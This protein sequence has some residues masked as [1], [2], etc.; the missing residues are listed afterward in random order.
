MTAYLNGYNEVLKLAGLSPG[1]AQIAKGLAGEG[2]AT[3]KSPYNL[4]KQF[5]EQ[6]RLRAL[7]A[8]LEAGGIPETM[9]Y[10]NADQAKSVSEIVD[11]ATNRGVLKPPPD[12][13]DKIAPHGLADDLIGNLNRQ[14]RMDMRRA[15]MLG[16]GGEIGRRHFEDP[17]EIIVRVPASEVADYL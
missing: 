12:V 3:L 8:E 9:A 15:T 17:E 4:L 11:L 2:L 10:G 5:P 13:G 1:Y 6:A 16:M 7:K 14:G